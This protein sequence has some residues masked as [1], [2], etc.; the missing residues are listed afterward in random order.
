MYAGSIIGNDA[1]NGG[2]V[3]VMLPDGT[4]YPTFNLR[5][6]GA[7]NITHNTAE[8]NGGGVWLDYTGIMY[9]ATNAQNLTITHNSTEG[10]GGGIFTRR[11]QYTDPITHLNYPSNPGGVPNAYSN[12]TLRGNVTFGNNTA[13][14]L[15]WPPGNALA[16]VPAGAFNGAT[17]SQPASVPLLHRHPLN[18]YD[19][20]F[21]MDTVPFEFLKTTERLYESPAVIELLPGA[22]FRVFRTHVPEFAL[23]TP[24]CLGD[25]SLV[26]PGTLYPLGPWQEVLFV[27]NSTSMTSSTTGPIAFE[28][29]PRFTYQIIEETVPV[30]FQ[31][32][33]GQWRLSHTLDTITNIFE[34]NQP[35]NIGIVHIPSF[36]HRVTPTYVPGEGNI[37]WHLGNFRQIELPLT[38]GVGNNI[39]TIFGTIVVGLAG[40]ISLLIV[41]YMKRR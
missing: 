10:D 41:L 9:M 31:L 8:N 14:R 29:D 18:N 24:L 37:Y 32:P 25:G 40:V 12:I 20:N 1:R 13:S 21:R 33:G 11:L 2:G 35:Q 22:G 7:K 30:G 39:F 16:V 27:N 15:F 38:G 36:V 34:L 17:T 3:A 6:T 5:G 4:N 23:D 26:I 19:I 28:M